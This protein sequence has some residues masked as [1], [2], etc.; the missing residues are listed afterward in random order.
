M[1][2][3]DE[4]IT[5]W[6]RA[7]P[8]NQQRQGPTLADLGGLDQVVADADHFT[9]GA[10]LG[11]LVCAAAREEQASPAALNDV[12]VTGLESSTRHSAFAHAVDT[13]AASPGLARALGSKATRALLKRVS[14]AQDA[15]DDPAVAL[16]GAEAAECLT[17]LALAGAVAPAR[18]LGT[19]DE[20]TEDAAALPAEFA[21]RLP[22]LLGV[23]DAHHPAAGMREALERCLAP[24]HTFRDAAF[25]LALGDVRTALQQDSYR[26]MADQLKDSRQRFAQLSAA[27]PDRLDARIYM[28]G[29]D[30][31]LGLS[32]PNAPERVTEAAARLQEALER[33]RAWRS[34][35]TTPAWA[36]SREED[37]TAW[38]ELTALLNEAAQHM[39]DADPWYDH[40]QGILTA[41][42]RAYTAHHTVTVVTE[43]PAHAVVEQMVAPVVE[44]AFLRHDNR[45]RVLEHALA[46]DDELRNDPDAQNLRA[47]LAARI[48]RTET[49]TPESEVDTGKGRRWQQLAR[50][51]PDDF[52]TV[53]DG[54]PDN[55]LDRLELRLRDSDD[56]TQ[57][58]TD[59]KYSRLMERIVGRL[60][61][62]RDW[63]PGIAQP[64]HAL[65]D[66]TVHYALRC[67]DVGRTMGGGYTEFLRLRDK[68]GKKQKVDESLFHQHYRE[69]LSFTPLFRQVH[70]EVID[71]AGGRA[72]VVFTF[73]TAQ[74]NVECKIEEGDASE[75]GLHKYVSQATE[76]QNTGP[77][78]AVLLVLD[79]TV[80]AEGAVNFFDSV[81]IEEVQRSGEMEP[82]LVV[83]IR[84]PGG[85]DN[86]N[87]LRPAS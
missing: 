38:A 25:E 78:F 87:Q 83:V 24:D 45:M 84:V 12:I 70:T 33:Y 81:W 62:S 86:P 49:N 79:K 61:E 22:R 18:L 65:L 23:L 17:Q 85:R 10:F 13:L 53:T 71:K 26:Q 21:S 68:D 74:F 41:L 15:D 5:A 64:F 7:T 60:R 1:Q 82:C 40:C 51:F 6:A 2:T 72:D 44:D 11:Y 32:A 27:D 4:R 48:R 36:R 56:F 39:G 20:V 59:P 69:C 80:G 50:Q 29:I 35:T 47:A 58:I 30:G 14:D 55:V 37:I 31:L 43:T 67:Y 8:S 42:L 34:R 28:A 16:I 3:L 54:L 46:Y 76:Y 57:S 66:A 77:S 19:M 75:E 73:S 52:A 9:N 63:I